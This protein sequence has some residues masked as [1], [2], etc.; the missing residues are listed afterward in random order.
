MDTRTADNVLE[1]VAGCVMVVVALVV[2]LLVAEGII[3]AL[4]ALDRALFPRVLAQTPAKTLVAVFAHADDEGTVAPVLARYAREGVDVYVIVATDGAQGGSHTSIP[5]G[6]ELAFARAQESRCAAGALG[7]QA[8]ILLGFPDAGLG[9]Y[10]EERERLPRLTMRI[11]EELQ[12][13]RPDALIS[14]GPDGATGHPDHRL[15]STIVT[16][17][18]RAGAPGA[19]E[20]LFYAGLP[21]EAIRAMD[22]GRGE[23]FLMPMA[24][25]FT[26]R[27]AFSTADFDRARQSMA[28]HKT[29][30]SADVMDR[31]SAATRDALNGTLPLMPWLP[32]PSSTDLFR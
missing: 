16:Q 18:V 24:K 19:T 12:R 9:S 1:V 4:P 25:Y 26:A 2:T 28:C 3:V 22:P 8:P 30:Y 29:Q 15:V 27:I 32:S 7:I 11:Q 20:R 21:A 17:L 31:I 13:L 6:S 5:R 10:L 23:T 14:W